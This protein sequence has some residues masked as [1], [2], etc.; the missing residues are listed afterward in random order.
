MLC[1]QDMELRRFGPLEATVIEPAEKPAQATIV[2]LHGFGAPGTDLVGLAHELRSAGPYRF[3]FPQAPLLLD[4]ASGPLGGRAWW[5][6]DMIALQV[7][8]MSRQYEKL[9]ADRPAGL[10]E[11]SEA[12]E[13][14]L[15]A[16]CEHFSLKPSELL[17]GGFSQGAMLSC[18][19]TL[20]RNFPARALI[21]LSG[22]VLC[23]TDWKA[24]LNNR[25]SQQGI[26]PV[27]QSHSPGDEVLPFELAERL[28]LLFEAEKCPVDFVSFQ[29]GHGISTSVLAGLQGF[30]QHHA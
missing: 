6:I 22:T 15:K 27:F 10:S 30:L 17:L 23:E 2:L 24:G 4:P 29:G 7:A 11:A 21:Q 25:C 20:A 26:L 9:A 8:R 13:E 19:L 16:L 14:S 28:K 18:H 3:V 5:N 1:A 12:L